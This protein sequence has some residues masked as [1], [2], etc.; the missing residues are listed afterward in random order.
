MRKSIFNLLMTGALLAGLTVPVQ[1]DGE[2]YQADEI[3]SIQDGIVSW[4][5]DQM[6]ID[7]KNILD[8][9]VLEGAGSSASDWLA[10]TMSRMEQPDNQSGYLSALQK[11]IETLYEDDITKTVEE[12][13]LNPTDFYR[14]IL[15][16]NACGGDALSFGTDKENNEI[17]L[18]EDG[19]FDCVFENQD[20]GVQGANGYIWALLALDSKDYEEPE[21][22]VWTRDKLVDAILEKEQEDGGFSLSTDG[23]SDVDITAMALTALASYKDEEK[24]SS[25]IENGF[26]WL[27]SQQAEDG[28]MPSMGA[29]SVESTDWTLIAVCSNDINPL[30]DARF[31]KEENSLLDGILQFRTED[32]GIAHSLAENENAP[33]AMAGYQTLYA[34]ES[35]RRYQQGENTLFDLSDAPETK[36]SAP[37]ETTSNKM[38]QMAG[39]LIALAVIILIVIVVI[40]IRNGHNNKKQ[41]AEKLKKVQ[42]AEEQDDWN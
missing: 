40:V 14:A 1:A 33:D 31:L 36:I 41:K 26:S 17:N 13:H 10:F 21:D 5:K 37:E 39:I 35:Y 4:E 15:T 22:A 32:G 9:E 12:Q 27:S 25:A 7:G 2:K 20:P 34:L 6:G 29:E 23:D 16:V 19:I 11:Q 30:E 42:E 24:V 28:A 8:G 3:K 38:G 18:V